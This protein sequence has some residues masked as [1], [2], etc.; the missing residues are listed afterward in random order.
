MTTIIMLCYQL[1][2]LDN[3]TFFILNTTVLEKVK[4]SKGQNV[5]RSNNQIKIDCI[6]SEKKDDM[7]CSLSPFS[8]IDDDEFH[9]LM[10]DLF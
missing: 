1:F 4:I 3:T 5:R 10:K 7:I 8:S 6:L 9:K 2:L